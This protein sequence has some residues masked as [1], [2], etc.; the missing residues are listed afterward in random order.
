MRRKGC[1]TLPKGF[2]AVSKNVGIFM[3]PFWNLAGSLEHCWDF[4][5][6]LLPFCWKPVKPCAGTWLEVA[7]ILLEPCWKLD[8]TLLLEPLAGTFCWE[9]MRVSISILL[10]CFL[11][12]LVCRV[13]RLKSGLNFARTGLQPLA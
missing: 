1:C 9:P 3:E 12:C 10:F 4:V 2:V 13:V 6:T 8:G 5:G 11:P 7:E